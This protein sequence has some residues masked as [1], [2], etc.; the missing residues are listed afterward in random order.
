MPDVSF[1]KPTRPDDGRNM[2]ESREAKSLRTKGDPELARMELSRYDRLRQPRMSV[3]DS[4]WQTLSNYFIPSLSDINEE[5][6]EGTTGWGD[7]V[8]DTTAIEDAR[9]CTTGQTN[10]ATPMT[11]PW[12]GWTPPKNLNMEEDDDGAI[13]CGMCS[14]IALDE[15]ARSNYYKMSGLQYQSRT[16]FG[17]GH[18]HIEEGKAATICCSHRKISTYCI[19]VNDEGLVDTVYSEFK[20]TARAAA[21]KFGP[22]NLGPKVTKALNEDK[23]KGLDKEFVFLHVIRPR[24]SG[25]RQRGAIDGANKP[26]AS[27][28][29]GMEDK[30]C[31]RVAGYDEMPDSVTRFSD[32]GSNSPWGYSPAFET[33]PNVRQL[34]YVVRFQDAQYELRANPR[35]LEPI[36]L[37]G[38]VDLRPGGRTAFDPN[39]GELGLPR[40][41]ATAADVSGTEHAIEMKQKA[42]HRLFYADVFTMLSQIDRKMTAYE[43]SQRVGEKLEQLSPMFSTLITEK[44]SPDLKRIF[45][46]LYRAGKFPRPPKS[47]FV[48]DATGRSLKLAMPEI[49]YTSRLAL[50]L[51][52]LQN[53]ATMDTMQFMTEFAQGSGHPEVLDNFNLD[54]TSRT[55]A[56]NQG[57]SPRF[58]RPYKQ[59]L[60]I[61]K[62]R[63]AQQQKAQALATMEQTAKAA[64]HLGGAPQA[65]QDAV[66][67]QLGG[68]TGTEG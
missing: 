27:I 45:G 57:M 19:A 44:T 15:L 62:A 49:T 34:N 64:K 35:I 29:I 39:M 14:E 36:G 30:Y 38:D 8:F 51:K 42:V 10:W 58:L 48:P 52:S 68:A 33:L 3:F 5:K 23:G 26:I 1:D 60:D 6:T 4:A 37:W 28:Y 63:A 17:T 43:I 67:D 31:V 53:K 7:R 16:V 9:T 11:E 66:T 40:E 47:M 20:M 2:F 50:A 21:Q 56:I 59:V 32:W 65:M 55:F 61:R 18:L 12:F 13:W 41:W 22:D 24:E 54:E 25:E 46:I